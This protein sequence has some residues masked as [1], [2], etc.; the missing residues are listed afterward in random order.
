[1]R[2]KSMST[3]EKP[4]DDPHQR[5]CGIA[6]AGQMQAR[7]M[8]IRPILRH[9][10]K[11]SREIPLYLPGAEESS[12][13]YQ[14]SQ[15]PVCGLFIG[16]G[17]DFGGERVQIFSYETVPARSPPRAPS[18]QFGDQVEMTTLEEPAV[19]MRHRHQSVVPIAY[20]TWRLPCASSPEWQ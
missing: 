19:A 4:T 6:G 13:R 18:L 14:L 5:F 3:A 9:I 17:H 12:V 10:P 11:E 7:V 8:E 1:M 16:I 20:Q 2:T 15:K